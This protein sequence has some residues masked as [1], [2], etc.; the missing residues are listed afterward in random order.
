MGAF[1][2]FTLALLIVGLNIVQWLLALR[3]IDALYKV[4]E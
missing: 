2:L 1:S 3:L 4:R